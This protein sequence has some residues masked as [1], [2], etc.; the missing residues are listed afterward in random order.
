MARTEAKENP[1]RSFGMGP[2]RTVFTVHR[3]V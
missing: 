2:Q 3:R 1:G